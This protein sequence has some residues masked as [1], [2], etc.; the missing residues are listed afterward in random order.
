MCIIM[1]KPLTKNIRPDRTPMTIEEYE[2]AGGY[3]ALRKALTHVA[4]GTSAESA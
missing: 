3:Q 2:M 1:E 4:A